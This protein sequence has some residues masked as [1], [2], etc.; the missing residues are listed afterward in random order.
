M[1]VQVILEV[2]LTLA[3]FALLWRLRRHNH[4]AGWLFLLYLMF[5]G[6]ERLFVEFFRVKD[7][8]FFGV[9]TLAQAISIAL[10]VG[11]AIGVW[12]FS[13]RRSGQPAEATAG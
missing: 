9:L 6:V 1:D 7:D 3:I 5:A 8:R 2:V 11:G 13:K 12:S 10:I 4:R